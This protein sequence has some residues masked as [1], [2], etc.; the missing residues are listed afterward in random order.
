MI[1][2]SRTQRRRG[3]QIHAFVFVVTMV[4][5]AALNFS[6]GEPYWIVWPLIGWGVGV[7]AH[8]WFTLGPGADIGHEN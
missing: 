1:H 3:V 7:L 5:L 4:L 8:W 6:I 2:T